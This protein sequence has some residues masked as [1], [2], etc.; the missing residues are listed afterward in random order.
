[1]GSKK[2]IAAIMAHPDD[3]VLG[4]GG[5]LARLSRSGASVHIF[6]LATGL[7]SRGPVDKAS[8]LALKNQARSAAN[9]LGAT[10]IDFANFPDNSMDSVKLLDIVKQ[11]ES[12]LTKT[13]PDLIFTHH[14]GDINIDHDLT[15]RAVM[16]A[17]RALPGTQPLD[18]LACEVS[19]S[20]EFGPA[21][22]RL[23]PHL[24][25][26]LT[27]DDVKAAI[28]ALVCYEGEIRDWPHPR[29]AKALEHQL[30]LRGAECGVE[31]AEVFE[32]L[33]MVR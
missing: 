20:T 10:T 5:S 29:S 16:T 17:T 12:F 23:Q 30:R 6:I 14:N 9:R 11:V 31:A 32:V 21:N 7:T 27:E 1:M 28:D 4:C 3:E 25:I 24:Y 22:K 26:R 19:S 8:L 15:Q 13:K 2:H 33:R 18:V